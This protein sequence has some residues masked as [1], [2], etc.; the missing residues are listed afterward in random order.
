MR[1]QL[2]VVDQILLQLVLKLL[3]RLKRGALNTMK[4]NNVS[5]L[6]GCLPPPFTGAVSRV[7]MTVKFDGSGCRGSL[8]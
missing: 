3:Q 7:K 4:E 5:C 1:A 6:T 2:D 8:A